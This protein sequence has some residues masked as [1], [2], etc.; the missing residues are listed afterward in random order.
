MMRLIDVQ[1][2]LNLEIN[3]STILLNFYRERFT[4]CFKSTKQPN[5]L[6][7]ITSVYSRVLTKQEK[8]QKKREQEKAEDNHNLKQSKNDG[9]QESKDLQKFHTGNETVMKMNKSNYH[10]GE[11]SNQKETQTDSTSRWENSST[12]ASDQYD[13]LL[14]P[15]GSHGYLE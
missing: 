8:R 6:V 7:G 2:R 4:L 11:E 15:S 3:H 14:G 9:D 1:S 10:I 5:S 12:S 13:A